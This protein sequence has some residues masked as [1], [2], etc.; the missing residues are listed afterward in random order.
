MRLSSPISQTDSISGANG[1]L[2]TS[3]FRANARRAQAKRGKTRNTINQPKHE[4]RTRPFHRG[5][6]VAGLPLSGSRLSFWQFLED[7]NCRTCC[8]LL[9]GDDRTAAGS[10]M[11]DLR[12]AKTC[13]YFG[14]KA[15]KFTRSKSTSKIRLKKYVGVAY[16]GDPKPVEFWKRVA[17]LLWDIYTQLMKSR[18][19]AEIIRIKE[20]KR[21]A[22]LA[23]KR[24]DR[25]MY[26][27]G[28][29]KR[30]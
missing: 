29:R 5:Y 11:A 27:R 4:L 1:L 7:D 23:R 2:T 9:C 6:A 28:Y 21:P 17:A 13:H 8:T 16:R 24:A 25:A 14:R 26:M 15:G 30:N 19:R 12:L 10:M 18:T 20:A 3:D 22:R